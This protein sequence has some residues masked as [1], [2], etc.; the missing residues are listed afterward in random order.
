[1]IKKRHLWAAQASVP[2]TQIKVFLAP[3]FVFDQSVPSSVSQESEMGRN[4]LLVLILG[5]RAQ[6]SISGNEE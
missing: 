6:N 2:L 4:A 3:Y 5:H 1:L